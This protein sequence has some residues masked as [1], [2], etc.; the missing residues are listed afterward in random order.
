MTLDTFLGLVVY[1]LTAFSLAW[2]TAR[3]Q[4]FAP[5]RER[6]QGWFAKSYQN[7]KTKWLAGQA[8]YALSCATCQAFWWGLVLAPFLCNRLGWNQD[9]LR[10]GWLAVL[11]CG[12]TAIITRNMRNLTQI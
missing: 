5:I 2:I 6:L 10:W 11:A 1:C 12:T 9:V 3:E 4:V 7:D 8:T